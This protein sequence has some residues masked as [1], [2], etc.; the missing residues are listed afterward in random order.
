MGTRLLGRGLSHRVSGVLS[1]GENS[2]KEVTLKP[3]V[4]AWVVQAL[5]TSFISE[6]VQRAGDRYLLTSPPLGL[7]SLT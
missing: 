7:H 1:L 6:Y 3:G 2:L 5:S 4:L